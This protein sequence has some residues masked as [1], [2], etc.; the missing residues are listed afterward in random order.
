MVIVLLTFAAC[1]NNNDTEITGSNWMSGISDD[2]LISMI[3]IPST[4]DSGSALDFPPSQCQ[5]L[6]LKEQLEAGVRGFDLRLGFES[7]DSTELQIFHGVVNQEVD[8]KDIVNDFKTFLSANPTETVIIFIKNEN[9]DD[10][11]KFFSALNGYLT[12]E[13][14]YLE[15]EIPKLSEVRGKVVLLNRFDSS[16]DAGVQCADGW[17]DNTSFEMNNGV[18]CFVQDYYNLDSEDNLSKKWTEIKNLMEED[19]GESYVFNFTSG[20][21]P[22]LLGLPNIKVVSDYIHDKL[23]NEFA[24]M[25]KG[26][27]GLVLVDFIDEDL[28]KLIYEKNFQ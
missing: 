3:S 7:D 11:E 2:T 15:N 9:G 21:V 18:K 16:K 23:L 12:D 25:P 8:F 5:A 26:N 17:R 19:T 1:N 14:F 6:T 22:A 27:Y 13:I 20:Y 24:S 4:H 28:S 10:R